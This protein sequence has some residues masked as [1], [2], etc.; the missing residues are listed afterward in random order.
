AW[1]LG[2]SVASLW[3]EGG[4]AAL[5]EPFERV[6]DGASAVVRIP[7][8]RHA[9]LTGYFDELERAGLASGQDA[10]SELVQRS[11][12]TLI[13]AEVSQASRADTALR[14]AGGGLVVE[15]LRYIERHALGPLTL[16]DIAAA[17]GRSPSHVT[18]ALTRATGRSA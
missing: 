3:A 9:R 7:T 13:L 10:L 14:G 11:L 6:R 15:A 12:V 5:F 18:S 1:T 2:L 4:G 16:E 8:G 17:V